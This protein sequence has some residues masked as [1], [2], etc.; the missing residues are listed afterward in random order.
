LG[1]GL[2]QIITNTH[3]II[4]LITISVKFSI[5]QFYYFSVASW[6]NVA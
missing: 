1:Y 4:Y 2:D 3:L 5:G 6:K